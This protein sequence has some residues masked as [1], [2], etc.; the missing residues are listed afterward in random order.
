MKRAIDLARSGGW[1]SKN[2]TVAW[3]PLFNGDMAL[4]PCHAMF[5]VLPYHDG[6]ELRMDQ[7]SA[8]MVLGAPYNIV[9]YALLTHLIAS[10]A[11]KDALALIHQF[12]DDH[13]YGDH[14]PVVLEQLERSPKEK[15]A[16]EMDDDIGEFVNEVIA[17]G[18]VDP[19]G[20]AV[21]KIHLT[22]Y[23][24]E[25]GLWAPLHTGIP[26]PLTRD[27]KKRDEY[28]EVLGRKM[29]DYADFLEGKKPSSIEVNG[30]VIPVHY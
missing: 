11:G 9:S 2:V 28:R 14:I 16:L 26:D 15:P 8:D 20:E 4:E 27:A 10:A 19:L 12:G 24:P 30:R 13:I 17:G 7:R 5:H 1:T 22:R 6:I 23:A 29:P 18:V 3:N 21:E 25:K